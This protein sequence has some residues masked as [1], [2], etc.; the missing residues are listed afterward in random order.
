MARRS[1]H[2]RIVEAD[3]NAARY[4]GNFNEANERGDRKAAER[5]FWQAQRWLDKANDLRGMGSGDPAP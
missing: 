2:E 3:S 4:L 5:L 1:L